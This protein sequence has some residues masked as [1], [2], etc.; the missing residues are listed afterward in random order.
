MSEIP[1]Y[2]IELDSL[3]YEIPLS[4][5][6]LLLSEVDGLIAGILALPVTVPNDEWLPLIWGG[7]SKAFPRNAKKSARLVELILAR[8]AEIIGRFI[9]GG[10]AYEP[11]YDLDT[12]DSELWEIWL[13]SF[14]IGT[15]IRPDAA[16]SLYDSDDEDVATA[17]T[18]IRLLAAIMNG[19]KIDRK[20]AEGLSELAPDLLGYYAETLYRCH[21]GFGR[22][23]L[24]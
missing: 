20:L 16:R 11:I 15:D 2:L 17:I 10:M 24:D 22:V 5:D 19:E 6:C 9:T 7:K 8:K 21:K 23:V 3:L 14:L 1:T 4:Q 13:E 18:G 12:D